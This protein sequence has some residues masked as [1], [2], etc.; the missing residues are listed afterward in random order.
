MKSLFT[1]R[2][3]IDKANLRLSNTTLHLS[4][5]LLKPLRITVGKYVGTTC[6]EAFVLACIGLRRSHVNTSIYLFVKG[7]GKG[8]LRPAKPLF[9]GSIP[10]AASFLLTPYRSI[11]L[12]YIVACLSRVR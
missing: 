5:F 6:I 3:F 4:A 12:Q 7:S 11:L 1:M 8:F 10:I 2:P 9:I